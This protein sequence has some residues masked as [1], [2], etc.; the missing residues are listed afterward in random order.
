MFIES[1]IYQFSFLF[2]G[3]EAD[4][5]VCGKNT[6]GFGKF[7]GVEKIKA[8]NDCI[9]DCI[10]GQNDCKSESDIYLRCESP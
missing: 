6:D 9:D 8:L 7:W 1:I 5:Y 4:L 10:D 2:L 3:D